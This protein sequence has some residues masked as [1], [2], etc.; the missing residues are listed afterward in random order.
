MF[1]EAHIDFNGDGEEYCTITVHCKS[2][3]AP[4][5]K[6]ALIQEQGRAAGRNS[7]NRGCP[8]EGELIEGEDA[9]RVEMKTIAK[10]VKDIQ[11]DLKETLGSFG[12]K[13]ENLEEL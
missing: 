11:V 12:E 7:T 8:P 4:Q 10:F 3:D 13:V 9:V 2:K 5:I 1:K 6:Q